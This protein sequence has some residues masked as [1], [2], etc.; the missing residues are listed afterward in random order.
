M[1]SSL[2]RSN[3]TWVRI[4]AVII[5]LS[6]IIYA[7]IRAWTVA[8]THDEAYTYLHFIRGSMRDAVDPFESNANNHMLNTL[9]C[10]LID[11]IFGNHLLLMRL[12]VV[13]LFAVYLRYGYRLL[14]LTGNGVLIL[15]GLVFIS[16][17]PFLLDFA[18]LIRGYSGALACMM[19]SLYYTAL[20]F[21]SGFQDLK[22]FKRS[23]FAIGLSVFFH[24]S[25]LNM[26]VPFCGVLLLYFLIYRRQD[27]RANFSHF[28]KS[29]W[30]ALLVIVIVM[31]HSL[32]K[33]ERLGDTGDRTYG[34]MT[35]FWNDIIMPLLYYSS[36]REQYGQGEWW[37]WP[38]I[39]YTLYGLFFLAGVVFAFLGIRGAVRRSKDPS[40]EKFSQYHFFMWLVFALIILNII[41]QH[42]LLGNTYPS[43]RMVLFM[44]PLYMLLIMWLLGLLS[45]VHKVFLILPVFAASVFAAHIVN[46]ANFTHTM[47]W[48]FDADTDTMLEELRE[49]SKNDPKPV[50]LGIDW[51]LEPGANYYRMRYKYQDW[52]REFNRDG[53]KPEHDYFYCHRDAPLPVGKYEVIKEY[54][55]SDYRLIRNL[56]R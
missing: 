14:S 27:A 33:A 55:V 7:I 51:L 30:P 48:T 53:I 40:F 23:I 11:G 41:L 25:F 3:P 19:A 34:G 4:G 54:E 49:I 29:L 43:G 24:L 42:V 9:I 17:S 45:K 32:I 2:I 50:N 26:F 56:E 13:F 16:A 35:G 12:H 52:V 15:C 18:A 28:L 44:I 8:I 38:S 10:K 36:Y 6:F 21:R 20:C 1:Q 47:D 22:Y 39:T 31:T 5:G 46:T 37:H